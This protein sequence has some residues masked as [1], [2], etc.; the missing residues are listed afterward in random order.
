MIIVIALLVVLLLAIGAVSVIAL[1][2][3]S[4]MQVGTSQ[5]QP[6]NTSGKLTADK[7]TELSLGESFATNLKIGADGKDHVLKV[8]ISI[9]IDTTDEKK[10]TTEITNLQTKLT[11]LRD[12][13]NTVI[14]EATYEDLI[15]DGGLDTLKANIL[16][17]IQQQFTSNLIVA[18]YFGNVIH[19]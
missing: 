7:I 4:K 2:Q 18:V 19:M 12:I 8:D 16:S 6:E 3:L 10:A 15:A 13:A 14:R 9:G 5:Q 11:I 17:G 1:T